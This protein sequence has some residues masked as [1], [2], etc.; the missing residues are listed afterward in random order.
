MSLYK[1]PDSEVWW[2]NISHPVHPRLRESTGT[3]DRQEAQRIHDE[4]KAQLW[5]IPV[6]KGGPRRWG[7]AVNAWLDIEDR[8]ESELLSLRKFGEKFGD[9][10]LPRIT[11]E[12]V[13]HALAF[14]KTAGTYM[15]YRT[16][17][18]AILNIAIKR[19]WLHE[20]P[21]IPVRRDKK[22]KTRTWITHE[23]WDKLYTALPQ[24]LK[25]PA[26]FA[27][28]TGLRQSNVFGLCWRDVDLE[29]R[30]VTIYAED[31]KDD[32]HLAV[33]LNDEALEAVQAQAGVHAE[34]VFTYRKKP[35]LKPKAGFKEAC[36]RAGVPEF[37]W[38][39]LRHTWA[40]WHIQ[41]G[42]PLEVLQKLGGWSDLRMVMNYAHHAP[43]FAA[44]FVNNVR[45]KT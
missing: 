10:A 6:V 13:E 38:H 30:L 9:P 21:D 25:A 18:V 29:R 26:V 23:Q 31:L 41:N 24:H 20:M 27:L 40:T 4:K 5:S 16:M 7:D 34:F 32:D 11:G 28:N 44:Q 36:A 42:T 33:P 8:S 12:M 45:R 37:T 1:R 2:L 15:R 17:I 39:G 43:G 3:T 19:K 14:C 35:I 22:K